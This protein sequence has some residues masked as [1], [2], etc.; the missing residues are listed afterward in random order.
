MSNKTSFF[1]PLQPFR[2]FSQLIMMFVLTP[3][4]STT[5]HAASGARYVFS[6]LLQSC[7][8]CTAFAFVF[9]WCCYTFVLPIYLF[10]CPIVHNVRPQ[11]TWLMF[12]IYLFRYASMPLSL[13]SSRIIMPGQL[14]LP[15][16]HLCREVTNK[17]QLKTTATA[18]TFSITQPCQAARRW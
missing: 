4:K 2:P 8:H 9:G 5:F 14:F 13:P 15:S 18:P 11:N 12:F 7:Q 3:R 17:L 16:S 10:T 1:I 6:L